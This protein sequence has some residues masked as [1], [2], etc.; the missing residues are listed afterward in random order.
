MKTPRV[1]FGV[2]VAVT[3]LIIGCTAGEVVTSPSVLPGP[4]QAAA[5][6]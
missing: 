2:I 3:A 5:P 6:G 4:D 1:P